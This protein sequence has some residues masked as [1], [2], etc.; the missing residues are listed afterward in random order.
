MLQKFRERGYRRNVLLTNSA[1]K[2]S[3]KL[4]GDH[5]EGCIYLFT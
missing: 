4:E 5:F 2:T 1:I 3:W